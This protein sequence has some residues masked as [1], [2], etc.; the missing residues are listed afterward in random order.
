MLPC[1]GDYGVDVGLVLRVAEVVLDGSRAEVVEGG[2]IGW[3]C[4]G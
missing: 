4:I 3:G 2:V 1:R